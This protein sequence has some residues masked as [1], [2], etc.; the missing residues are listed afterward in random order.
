VKR[1]LLLFLLSGVA[2]MAF[3]AGRW[4]RHRAPEI[5]TPLSTDN[6]PSVPGE[7]IA[8]ATFRQVP[9]FKHEPAAVEPTVAAQPSAP[10]GAE[11]RAQIER[12][13]ESEVS[14]LS[15]SAQLPGYLEVLAN[16]AIQNGIVTATEVE[17]GRAAVMRFEGELGA[18]KTQET[19]MAFST[20][21][22]EL[23]RRLTPDVHRAPPSMPRLG[24]PGEP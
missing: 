11:T 14:R 16:R 15:T 2:I 6:L 19:L 22:S 18:Q 20:R 4:D 17:P 7:A 9:I 12:R 23:S 8:E 1:N 21:M 10:D 24:Q 13:I 3:V 5:A